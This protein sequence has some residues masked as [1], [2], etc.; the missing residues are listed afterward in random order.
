[1]VPPVM[2]DRI[3]NLP[4]GWIV[5]YKDGSIVVEGELRWPQVV[6]RNIKSLSLKWHDKFWTI[7]DKESYVCFQRKAAVLSA[8]GGAGGIELVARCI[9]FYDEKGRK[10]IYKVDEQTGKMEFLVKEG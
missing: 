1:M 8:G 5:T 4:K 6:K 9:G 10:I 2:N 3:M 7:T